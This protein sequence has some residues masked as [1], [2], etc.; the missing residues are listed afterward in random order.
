MVNSTATGVIAAKGKVTITDVTAYYQVLSYPCKVENG[1]EVIE[2]GEGATGT[3]IPDV[4]SNGKV[5]ETVSNIM[6]DG[7]TVTL[8]ENTVITPA[9]ATLILVRN[10]ADEAAPGDNDKIGTT[11]LSI[12]SY[13]GLPDGL[14]F[15]GNPL[16]ISFADDYNGQLGDLNLEY[17]GTD[18]VWSLDP[19]GDKGVKLSGG[20]YT[21]NI[22]HF[23]KFRAAIDLGISE[24]SGVVKSDYTSFPVG[25]MNNNDVEIDVHVTCTGLKAG[26]K[27]EN[28]D[29]LVAEVKQKFSNENAQNVVLTA[30]QD[31]Y[32]DVKKEFE[33]VTLE[34]DIKVPAFTLLNSVSVETKEVTKP[35]TVTVNNIQ[36]QFNVLTVEYLKVVTLEKDMT[37]IGH[38]HGHGND[39]NAGGGI[40]V[41][42]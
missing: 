16:L 35:C 2:A 27:Y 21:M 23:S 26:V 19:K 22:E 13:I 10:L 15:A 31:A 40:I 12:R 41:G 11:P 20:V 6:A 1:K 32:A 38:S 30:I 3:I 8:K 42:E 5:L 33:T 4:D 29:Q 9:D 37:H 25:R 14:A 18:G 7:T 24:E 36:I 34:G 28:Y 17:E 39:L